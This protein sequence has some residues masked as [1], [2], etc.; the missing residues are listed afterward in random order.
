MG[1]Y[2][3]SSSSAQFRKI[4]D[5]QNL[6]AGAVIDVVGVLQSVSELVQITRRDG[7]DTHKR[8]IRYQRTCSC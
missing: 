6:E 5:V 3:S 1:L 2:S 4:G 8:T 7:T